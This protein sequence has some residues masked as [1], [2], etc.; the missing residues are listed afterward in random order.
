MEGRYE[1]KL[2][3]YVNDQFLLRNAFIKIKAT[4]DV[5]AESWSLTES[6]A[7]KIIT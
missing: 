5:T 6:I 4:A 7:V 1:S 3:T 2:E